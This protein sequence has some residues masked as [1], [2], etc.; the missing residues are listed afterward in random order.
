MKYICA[1]GKG[2]R[3]CKERELKTVQLVNI[4]SNKI[5][6][7]GIGICVICIF[8]FNGWYYYL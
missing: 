1:V 5:F 6:F 2:Q 3:N 8:G 4:A 7:S